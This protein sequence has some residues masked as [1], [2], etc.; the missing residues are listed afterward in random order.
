MVLG[1]FECKGDSLG[2]GSTEC[3]VWNLEGRKEK[4]ATQGGNGTLL[5]APGPARLLLRI[6]SLI[7]TGVARLEA[8]ADACCGLVNDS[9]ILS[10][11]NLTMIT[12]LPSSAASQ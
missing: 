3:L 6:Q 9:N 8:K 1:I 4:M 10:S 7:G 2:Y 12:K 11:V 5:Y